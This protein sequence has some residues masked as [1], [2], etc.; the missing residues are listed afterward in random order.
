MQEQRVVVSGRVADRLAGSGGVTWPSMGSAIT[1]V[2][3]VD[4]LHK[5]FRMPTFGVGR[6]ARRAG[7]PSTPSGATNATRPPDTQRQTGR[8]AMNVLH[9]KHAHAGS[10]AST[11]VESDVVD[12]VCEMRVSL[13]SPHRATHDGHEYLFCSAGCRAKFVNDPARFLTKAS[14]SPLAAPAPPGTQYTCPMHPEIIRDEPGHCPSAA[15]RS[16]R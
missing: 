8:S 9:G 10:H 4:L 7:S 1:L 2:L 16:S 12:P 13:E 3:T 5:E 15:W 6:L 14:P 11:N